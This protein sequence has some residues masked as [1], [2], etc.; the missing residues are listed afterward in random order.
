M[1]EQSTTYNWDIDPLRSLKVDL[2]NGEWGGKVAANGDAWLVADPDVPIGKVQVTVTADPNDPVA[3]AMAQNFHLGPNGIVVPDVALQ[4]SSGETRYNANSEFLELS[5]ATLDAFPDFGT[6]KTPAALKIEIRVAP[7]TE[8]TGNFG[9]M[10]LHVGQGLRVT[11]NTSAYVTQEPALPLVPRTQLSLLGDTTLRD[12]YVPPPE[13][14]LPPLAGLHSRPT[15]PLP[16]NDLDQSSITTDPD[17]FP[18]PH[19]G[20]DAVAP[21]SA[22]VPEPA[23]ESPSVALGVSGADLFTFNQPAPQPVSAPDQSAQ[24]I[25]PDID[26]DQL[27]QAIELVV[28]TQFGSTFMLQRKLGMGYGEAGRLM[29]VMETLKVVGPSEGSRARDVLM[30]VDELAVKLA[31]LEP[32]VG[33]LPASPGGGPADRL[34]VLAPTGQE[35]PEETDR[36]RARSPLW[37]DPADPG[38]EPEPAPRGRDPLA[39]LWASEDKPRRRRERPRGRVRRA[40]ALAA[41]ALGA[42][43]SGFVAFTV[44][45]QTDRQANPAIHVPADNGAPSPETGVSPTPKRDTERS[46]GYIERVPPRREAVPVHVIEYKVGPGDT[47]WDTLDGLSAKILNKKGAQLTDAQLVAASQ[48]VMGDSGIPVGTGP[49]WGRAAKDAQPGDRWTIHLGKVRAKVQPPR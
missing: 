4:A 21:G 28:T 15:P 5:Q 44:G 19:V 3:M 27:R 17:G 14:D 41:L 16:M 20:S 33:S 34:L 40:I 29:D 43:A 12:E 26:V 25:P 9:A 24:V 37:V 45:N 49:N 11:A 36:R 13:P 30:G 32:T 35:R 47:I 18:I 38:R 1:A 22:F 48:Q 31:A 23:T 46:P 39:G 6:G 10:N 8:V 42:V 7:I 2:P